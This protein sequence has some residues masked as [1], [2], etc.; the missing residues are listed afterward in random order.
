MSS[1]SFFRVTN[2]RFTFD[3]IRLSVIILNVVAPFED[4]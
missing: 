3:V 2:Q 4:G 1:A